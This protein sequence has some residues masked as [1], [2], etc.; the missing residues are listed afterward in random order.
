MIYDTHP[1]AAA[2]RMSN[3]KSSLLAGMGGPVYTRRNGAG[4]HTCRAN[5]WL[6]TGAP[7]RVPSAALRPQLQVWTCIDDRCEGLRR[8]AMTDRTPA[9]ASTLLSLLTP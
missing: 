2:V 6:P 5:K 8:Y 7:E 1:R 3:P 4:T 9:I